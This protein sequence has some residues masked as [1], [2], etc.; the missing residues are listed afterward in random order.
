LLPILPPARLPQRRSAASRTA[1]EISFIGWIGVLLGYAALFTVARKERGVGQLALML[2]LATVQIF[3]ALYFYQWS[4]TNSADANMYY[5]DPYDFYLQ[6]FGFGTQFVIWVVQSLRAWFGGSQL[7]YFL[8]FQGTGTWGLAYLL[9]TFENI[10]TPTRLPVPNALLL[11]LFMPGL[12][13]WTSFIGKDGFLF[14]AAAMA[15]WAIIDIRGRWLAF[16][17]SVLIMLLFRAHVGLIAL[18]SLAVALLFDKRASFA[19]KT[20]LSML[21]AV[22]FIG[23]A[24]TIRSTFQLDV[25]SAESVADFINKHSNVGQLDDGGTTVAIDSFPVRVLSL[26]FRPFFFDASGIPGLIASVENLLLLI[27]F[28]FLFMRAKVLIALFKSA[29]LIRYSVVF[30]ILMIILLSIIYYNLGLGLRQKMMIMPALLSILAGVMLVERA[31]APWRRRSSRA[32]AASVPGA[33]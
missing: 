2:A 24:F 8:L 21:A 29:I 13:F 11:L 7:D 28:G 25:T 12:H 15:G 31:R 27:L 16:S 3:V 18:V 33:Q 19:L 4:Q 10:Y 6:G 17:V 32:E 23:A 26:L 1:M 5:E 22:G 9:K 20:M 14:L 30:A